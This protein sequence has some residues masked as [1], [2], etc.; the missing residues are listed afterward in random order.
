MPPIALEAL[1]FS[2][3]KAT[4]RCVT[5]W[6]YIDER[7][8]RLLDAGLERTIISSP[9]KLSFAEAAAIMERRPKG[10]AN[11]KARAVLLVAERNLNLWNLNR[12]QR[13]ESAR[14]REARLAGRETKSTA[15]GQRDDGSEGFQRT[16]A[17][18]LVDMALDLYT[19]ASSGLMRRAKVPIPRAA[20]AGTES[21][22]RVASAPLRRYIDGQAQRQ[23]LAVLCDYGQPMTLAECKEVAQ[24]A[25]DARNAIANL[26]AIRRS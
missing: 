1:S 24:V 5:L 23:L 12:R 15:L 17:H 6:V 8:G 20:G 4:N 3:R 7:S 26:R 14:K 21:G 9:M 22:G 19:Y 10:P 2:D 25:N 11:D 16:R 13:S 18:R